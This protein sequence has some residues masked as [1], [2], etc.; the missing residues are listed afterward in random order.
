MAMDNNIATKYN[1]VNIAADGHVN[2][3]FANNSQENQFQQNKQN[4]FSHYSKINFKAQLDN[5]KQY[6]ISLNTSLQYH[7]DSNDRN[8]NLFIE[9][10]FLRKRFLSHKFEIGNLKPINQEMKFGPSKITRGAGGVRGKYLEYVNI[11][12][13]NNDNN[14]SFILLNQSPIG[15][16]IKAVANNNGLSFFNNSQ[17]SIYDTNFRGVDDAFKIN[18]YNFLSENTTFGFSYTPN[19][20][21]NLGN[22]DYLSNELLNFKNV[23]NIAINYVNYLDNGLKFSLSSTIESANSSNNNYD[24]LLAYDISSTISYFGFEL[25]ILYG[26]W[27]EFGMIKGRKSDRPSYVSSALAYNFGPIGT[28]ISFLSSKYF[29]NK[30]NALSMGTDYKFSKNIMGFVELTKFNFNSNKLNAKNIIKDNN[31]YV[32]LTG[33]NYK[34]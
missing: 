17:R 33:I 14:P 32:L 2:L 26:K 1:F 19:I 28:S 15:H 4:L 5:L 25:A 21:N 8:E 16:N 34:F 24:D 7:I 23:F 31:G 20:N 10:I 22:D 12:L 6:D 30:Y 18:Y 3:L 27:Q 29:N 11:L 13:K 9:N